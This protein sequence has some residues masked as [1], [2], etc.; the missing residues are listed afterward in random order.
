MGTDVLFVGPSATRGVARVFDFWGD[1][2]MYNVSP[3]PEF[4]DAVALYSDFSVVGEDLHHAMQLVDCAS[5]DQL[6]LFE[7]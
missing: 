7:D 2:T 5:P 3:T 4:A 1:L 6:S